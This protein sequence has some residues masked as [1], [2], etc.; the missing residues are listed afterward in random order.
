MK[1][2]AH[3]SMVEGPSLMHEAGHS[4]LVHWDNPEGWAGEGRGRGIQDQ[5]TIYTCD[6]FMSMYGKNHHN[7]VQ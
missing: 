2:E 4:K 5:G 7:I 1:S 6:W 3:L